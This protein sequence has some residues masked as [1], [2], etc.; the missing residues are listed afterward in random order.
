MKRRIQ[1][2]RLSL[3]E[4]A[5]IEKKWHETAVSAEIHALIGDSS[6]NMVDKAG[7]VLYVVLGAAAADGVDREQVE[8]RIIR[9]ACNAVYEQA[10]EPDIPAARRASIVAGLEAAGRLISVLERKSLNDA[11]C[12][13][14]LKM[15]DQHVRW[16]DFERVLAAVAA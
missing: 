2:A 14:A 4:R 5:M 11:A 9:G 13:L 1:P 6:H 10:G 8:I 7:R 12:E 3:S 15:R 16:N